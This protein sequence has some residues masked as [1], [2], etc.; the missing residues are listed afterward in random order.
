MA[1]VSTGIQIPVHRV[2]PESRIVFTQDGKGGVGKT[3][4]CTLLVEWYG[5]RNTPVVVIDMDNENKRT[6]SV[7]HFYPDA[8]KVN[9]QRDRGLDGFLDVLEKG[10]PIVVADMGAGAGEV[11]EQWFDAMHGQLQDIGVAFTAIG[12]VTPDP[13][14]VTSVLTWADFLEDRVDYVIVKN[15]ISHHA[16][17]SYWDND[18]DAA[19]FRAEFKPRVISM[20]YRLGPTRFGRKAAVPSRERQRG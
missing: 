1:T 9:I 16:D 17:F 2:Q 15:A 12:M 18:E 5:T 11:A 4:F 3:A 7:S 19:A 13:A 8:R 6:G 10:A 20:E 14:S